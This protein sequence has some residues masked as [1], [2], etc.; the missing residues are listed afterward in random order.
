MQEPITRSLHLCCTLESTLSSE[1]LCLEQAFPRKSIVSEDVH[2][3]EHDW[4]AQWLVDWLLRIR[5]WQILRTDWLI[6]YYAL[7]RDKF[8]AKTIS[9]NNFSSERVDSKGLYGRWRL[10]VMGSW[11]MFSCSLRYFANVPLFPKTPGRPSLFFKENFLLFPSKAYINTSVSK[12][13]LRLVLLICFFICCH[14][15]HN[16]DFSILG[17]P[18]YI[19]SSRS[20]ANSFLLR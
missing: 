5:L 6:A 7:G 18:W 15:S 17:I 4:A 13:R 12:Y 20:L 16:V 19:V 9:I 3:N 14:C 11:F 8:C 2:V 10:R 1:E